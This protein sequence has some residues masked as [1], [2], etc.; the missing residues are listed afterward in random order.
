MSHTPPFAAS[1]ALLA[2]F[3]PPLFAQDPG[4][5]LVPAGA[6]AAELAAAAATV[7][8]SPR[9]VA[10]QQHGFVAFVHFGTNTFTD[11]EWGEGTEDPAVFAPTDFD[12]G[13]W[14]DAFAAAGMRG[15][16]LTAKHHD[17]LCLWPTRS[18][19]H[20]IARA[21]WRSGKGDVVAAVAEACR[22]RGLSFGVYLSPWDRN[23]QAFG[24]PAYQEVFAAQLR[25]LCTDYGPLFEVWFDGANCPA[26]DPAMF[27]WQAMF[28]LVRQLQPNAAIAITGPDVRWV[29]NEA[30][31]TRK[32]EWSVL[33]LD[34]DDAGAFEHSRTAWQ[35]LWR[36]RARNEAPTLGSLHD[37]AGARRLCWW[38]AET[39]VS[40]RPGWFWHPQED[41]KVKPLSQLLDLWFT[42]VG[43]NAVL[44]LNVPPDRR[45]R[46]A[47]PDVAVLRDLGRWLDLTFATDL[48]TGARRKDY[49]RCTELYF[50]DSVT[51]DVLDLREDIAAN[52]QVVERFRIDIW[53][54]QEWKQLERGTT[55]GARRLLRLPP[56]TA[57]GVRCWLEASRAPTRLQH[58]SV[59]RQPVLLAA[60]TIA[61]GSDGRIAI[62]G[63]GGAAIHYTTDGSAPGPES[64]R[65]QE[66]FALPRGG[67]VRAIPVAKAGEPAFGG[68]T[69]AA[70][71]F[72]VDRARWTLVEVSSEQ[73]PGEA[74]AKAYDGDPDTHWHTRYAGDTP[75]P[76][77]ALAIDLGEPLAVS[78]F[79]LLPRASG[80][81][82]TI[83]DCELQVRGAADEP[84][85]TVARTTFAADDVHA[86]RVVRLD[87]PRPAVRQVRVVA[88]GEVRG[89]AWASLAEF[90]VL[91]D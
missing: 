21:P 2:A 7:R 32:A 80:D 55:I 40:I 58:L 52:G 20:S 30:G 12:A 61:R 19:D 44:L 77:H 15:V 1:L 71:T 89:R 60:P 81:N 75:Q 4:P 46:L 28:G 31:R 43:G 6:T 86:P 73:A 39:D 8:P 50:A 82:G 54:G 65:Y 67:T 29:G 59:H 17:G 37:L 34:T 74:A 47:D 10:W 27:D 5:V 9:Q 85:Q 76:P 16:V 22:A 83:A 14:I 26:D 70:A 3:A 23:H 63:Q 78:G 79:C 24:T 53:N 41:A 88:H 66:P 68:G 87:A 64:P 35:S 33:P 51:F 13:Q 72:G 90:E 91:V 45:G 56:T 42:A 18:T 57:R 49:A 36:L 84:W 48:A 11:R 62:R 38:P 25:E 69:A